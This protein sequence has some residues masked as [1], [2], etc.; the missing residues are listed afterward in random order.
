MK[1]I[2]FVTFD[3]HEENKPIKSIS[4]ATLEAYL[5]SKNKDI[6]IDNFSFNMNDEYSIIFDQMN[7]FSK[8][9]TKKYDY[10]CISMYA[11]NMRYIHLLIEHIKA[12]HRN[13]SII[14]GGYEVSLNRIDILKQDYLDIDHFI[15]GYAEE[16]LHRIINGVDLNSVLS[17]EVDN[18]EI[19]AIYN[20]KT[21]ELNSDSIVRLETKRGCPGKCTFCSYNSNDHKKLTCHNI[22]KI[23]NEFDY[24]N[25]INVKKVNV[26]DAIFTLH[27]YKEVLEY[28]V[29][30][31]FK[32]I[33]SLQMKF[34]IF[35][36]EITRDKSILELFSKLNIELE[37]GLQSIS[38]NVLDNIEREN[39]LDVIKHIV[40]LLNQKQIKYE[41]SIIRGLP[42]ETIDS[43]KELMMFMKDI[44][45]MKYVVYPLTLLTNTKL[46]ETRNEFKLI[47]HTQNGLEYVV[48][49]YSYTYKDY[50]E[51]LKLES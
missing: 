34:E 30:I 43:Y 28:L 16:S 7:A 39:N 19:P 42:G 4:I 41:I 21:I 37:F 27:S 26:I 2:L 50:I 32:P 44:K 36:N 1:K 33:L 3:F 25:K 12:I 38:K 18:S 23:K 20:N 13:I 15:I 17:I 29:A 14:A 5:K 11:W 47:T 10:I 45:C 8:L 48:G 24:L 49:S 22:K 35:N 51:M 46:Y 31:N 9:F 6:N 40:L